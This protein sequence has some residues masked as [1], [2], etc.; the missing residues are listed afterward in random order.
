VQEHNEIAIA[1]SRAQNPP[2]QSRTIRS[3]DV[4]VCY[5]G[6]MPMGHQADAL[7]IGREKRFTSRVQSGLSHKYA[8]RSAQQ[9]VT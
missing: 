2:A 4:C 9:R 5:F 8:A 1:V 3:H 6:V 7:N